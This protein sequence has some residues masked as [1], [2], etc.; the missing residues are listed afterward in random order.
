[1]GK[2]RRR[3]PLPKQL[4][5]YARKPLGKD[6]LLALKHCQV[7]GTGNGALGLGGLDLIL[8]VAELLHDVL[9]GR[10]QLAARDQIL[11]LAKLELDGSSGAPTRA[12]GVLNG[13]D[14]LVDQRVL[15]LVDVG[16]RLSRFDGQGSSRRTSSAALRA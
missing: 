8:A 6:L 5:R 16:R 3:S 10:T 15:V 13:L 2:G 9:G 7:D 14:V 1:M 12:G 11:G 4:C